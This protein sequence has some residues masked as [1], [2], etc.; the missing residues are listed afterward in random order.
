MA[1]LDDKSFLYFVDIAEKYD[2]PPG[3]IT[4]AR[5]DD[6]DTRDDRCIFSA[7]AS[8]TKTARAHLLGGKDWVVHPS[9]FGHPCFEGA[10]GSEFSLGDKMSVG[11]D[12]VESFVV[13]RTF[14]GLYPATFEPVQNFILYHELFYDR[15][16]K[17]Y[18]DPISTDPVIRYANHEHVLVRIEH[19]KDYLAARKMILVRFHD[20]RRHVGRPIT[21]AV[22]KHHGSRVVKN[23]SRF[24]DTI[25][26]ADEKET[27]SRLL[28]KDII[29]AYDEPR[30]HEYR[31]LAG[32]RYK[33]VKFIWKIDDDGNPVEAS[34]NRDQ[35]P[36]DF[37]RKV[38]FKKDV[39]QK[40]YG[41]TRIY[42]VTDGSLRHLDLWDIP[43]WQNECNLVFV[44][45][46]D[47]G[48][49]PYEEQLHWKQYNVAPDGGISETFYKRQIKGEFAE[50]GDPIHVI[51]H[52]RKQI[53]EKFQKAFGFSLFRELAK[54]DRY[55]L[56]TLHGLT[57]NEQKEFDEQILYMAK[58]FVDSLD[59]KSLKSNTRWTPESSSDDTTLKYLENFL[60]ERSNLEQDD[61]SDLIEIFRSVQKLR[62]LSTAHV[63]STKYDAYLTKT[64]LDQLEPRERFLKVSQTFCVQ[65]KKLQSIDLIRN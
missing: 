8:N 36:N 34:C 18:V 17:A 42:T 14:H 21:D 19:L 35:E 45:L 64:E 27:R 7:L 24:Y 22:R 53:N 48:R 16:K 62:S 3:W 28:G 50:S 25:V 31:L 5:F 33:F 15:D 56:D 12:V 9:D 1:E 51:I 23:D 30:H 29:T 43:H 26:Y 58:G 59:K 47:L 4:V 41:N 49:I 20:H 63:K 37:L 39:L 32:K 44:L 65:L 55:V 52:L 11:N 54:G 40:Y 60:R 6:P 61:V 38:Y 57:T 46:G 10:D 2:D 13:S